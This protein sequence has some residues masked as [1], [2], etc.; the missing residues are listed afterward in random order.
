[1]DL[2]IFIK[3]CAGRSGGKKKKNYL[4]FAAVVLI[5]LSCKMSRVSRDNV[6]K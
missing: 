4:D 1:M 3:R 5:P 2:I 6:L